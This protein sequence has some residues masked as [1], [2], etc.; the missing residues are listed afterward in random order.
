MMAPYHMW[1][2]G[3]HVYFVITRTWQFLAQ[4]GIPCS[5]MLCFN[6]ALYKRLRILKSS[7]EFQTLRKSILKVRLLMSVSFIFIIG[8]VLL[9]LPLLYDVS[10]ITYHQAYQNNIPTITDFLL[11]STRTVRYTFGERSHQKDHQSQWKP[12]LRHQLFLKLFC[13]QVLGMEGKEN[14]EKKKSQSGERTTKI[15]HHYFQ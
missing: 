4:A 1:R 8:Q 14:L 13:L 5:L 2:K 11:D 6:F 7:K 15:Y 10:M 3:S 9:W 12:D